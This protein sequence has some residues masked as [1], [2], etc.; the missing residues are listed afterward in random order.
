METLDEGQLSSDSLHT[1]G[2]TSCTSL[3]RSKVLL[4]VF[5]PD[6]N[7]MFFWLMVLSI[8]VEYNLWILILRQA[9][10]TIQVSFGNIV[11]ILISFNSVYTLVSFGNIVNKLIS[12][13]SVYTLVENREVIVIFLRSKCYGIPLYSQKQLRP[14]P[15]LGTTN[16]FSKILNTARN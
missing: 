12:F 13:N 11:S 3:L 15:F 2:T 4:T 5:H 1:T 7:F 8:T 9:F 14:N 6:G 10:P 16:D